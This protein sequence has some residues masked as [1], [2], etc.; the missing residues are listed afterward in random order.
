MLNI[1]ALSM[2]VLSLLAVVVGQA[3]LA[4][5]QVHLTAVEQR[6]QLAQDLHRQ[7]VLQVAELETPSRIVA[8]ALSH[9]L[10]SGG[11]SIQLPYVPLTTPL[12]TPHVTAASASTPTL[13]ASG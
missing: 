2:V 12:P 11:Q 13:P 7:E 5:G 1:V 4:D 10:I 6:L 9:G 8:A 3:L